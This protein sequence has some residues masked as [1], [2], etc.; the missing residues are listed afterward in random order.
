MKLLNNLRNMNM[1]KEYWIQTK[2]FTTQKWR[3][4]PYKIEAIIIG[5]LLVLI[6]MLLIL[7]T[8]K[9]MTK[10]LLKTPI[11]DIA[12]KNSYDNKELGI[13]FTFNPSSKIYSVEKASS[14]ASNRLLALV[15]RDNTLW[16]GQLKD[17]ELYFSLEVWK[18]GSSYVKTICQPAKSTKKKIEKI[19]VGGMTS[20]QFNYTDS[21]NRIHQDTC[22]MKNN[23]AYLLMSS[24]SKKY[25]NQD[26]VATLFKT[27]LNSFEVN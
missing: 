18:E 12:N 24:V 14:P 4:F 19:K 8:N 26:K 23:R 15:L 16:V 21:N 7:R 2:L 27:I 17:D 6:T 20:D 5:V 22:I 1:W 3:K 10:P 13:R 11:Q 9:K 25:G